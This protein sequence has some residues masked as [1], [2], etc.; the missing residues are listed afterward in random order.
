MEV[1]QRV[2]T[3]WFPRAI[4]H[5]AIGPAA[6]T[7]LDLSAWVGARQ[8]FVVLS[9]LNGSGANS[10]ANFRRN[11]EAVTS[12]ESGIAGTQSTLNGRIAYLAIVTDS[13]GIVEWFVSNVAGT[14]TVILEAYAHA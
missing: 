6:F 10:N 5:N 1:G 11:G 7:D 2:P 12:M 9:V 8:A 4:V 3:V 13:N 14:H